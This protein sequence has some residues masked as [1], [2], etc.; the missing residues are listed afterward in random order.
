EVLVTPEGAVRH[1]G[2][3]KRPGELEHITITWHPAIASIAVSSYSAL[4][5]GTGSFQEYGVFVRIKNGAQTVEIPAANTSAN[6]RSYTLCFGEILYGTEKDALEVSALELYSR[7][8]SE[9]RIGYKN[10]RVVMDIGPE[11][12]LK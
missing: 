7:P 8:D 6:H 1:G 11:G 12:Q 4:E 3:I 2:D 9:H 5:N 10:G